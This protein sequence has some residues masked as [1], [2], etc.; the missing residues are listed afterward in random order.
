M[1][2]DYLLQIDYY[3]KNSCTI[4]AYS[5][6]YKDAPKVVKEFYREECKANGVE[7]KDSD[8]FEITEDTLKR[9]NEGK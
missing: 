6:T 5:Y 1:E 4:K 7:P 8:T 3:K 9:L 2:F